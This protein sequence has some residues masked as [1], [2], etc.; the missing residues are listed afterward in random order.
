MRCADCDGSSDLLGLIG[1]GVCSR[2]HGDGKRSLSALNE[3]IFDTELE[4][5]E[6]G[7]SGTCKT[8]GGSGEA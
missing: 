6:C 7:G 1:N 2:C 4:C 8:C 5:L 3:A